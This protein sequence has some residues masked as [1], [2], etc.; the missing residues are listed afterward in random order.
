LFAALDWFKNTIAV[1]FHL[2]KQEKILFNWR[3]RNVKLFNNNTGA[4]SFVII[5]SKKYII[6]CVYTIL[7]TN[8]SFM[9]FCLISLNMVKLGQS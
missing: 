5:L 9:V 2:Y 4:D 6:S 8:E 1:I 7:S 3:I